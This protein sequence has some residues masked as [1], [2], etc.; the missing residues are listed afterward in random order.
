MSDRDP[1]ID[2][3]LSKAGHVKRF[4][5][6]EVLASGWVTVDPE[7]SHLITRLQTQEAAL[8]RRA[9]YDAEIAELIECGWL[10]PRCL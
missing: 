1:A 2:V 3:H 7:C 4:L 9:A 8:A 10:P 5:I 6:F